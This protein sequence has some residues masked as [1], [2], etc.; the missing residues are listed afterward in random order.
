MSNFLTGE[1]QNYSNRE[2]N[3]EELQKR[4]EG[5]TLSLIAYRNTHLEKRLEGKKVLFALAAS[6]RFRPPAGL[7][8]MPYEGCVLAFFKDDLRE[9]RDAFMKDAEQSAVRVDK[10][11]GLEV[12]VFEER[13]EED[14]W[15][16]FVAFPQD[17]VLLVATNE[18]FLEEVLARMGGTKGERAL[19]D[20]LR[21]WKY[22]NMKAQFWGLRHFDKT[23]ANKDP[24]SPFEGTKSANIPDDAAVGL[25]YECSPSKE[26]KA[27]ITYLSGPGA[28]VRKIAENMF[29]AAS[30][31]EATAALNI[32]Y[33][34]PEPGVIQ[35]EYDLSHSQPIN[36]FIF[37]LMGNLGHAVYL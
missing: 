25:T 26:R 4:F 9:R 6:R 18:E 13:S 14:V 29:P 19:A 11:K 34:T 33:R 31:P 37:I 12:A 16:S 20:T 10:V 5:Q 36:W 23:Q 27:T 8:E 7:G 22:V 21:E 28:D 17:G 30:E 15:T 24:T 3:G 1:E 35:S 32:R 2:V